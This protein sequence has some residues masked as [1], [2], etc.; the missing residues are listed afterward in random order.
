MY[1]YSKVAYTF[2]G[3]FIF[4]S[5]IGLQYCNEKIVSLCWGLNLSLKTWNNLNFVL[6]FSCSLSFI[7]CTNLGPSWPNQCNIIRTL[8]L[9][10]VLWLT[11]KKMF[12]LNLCFRVAQFVIFVCC[13]PVKG[14]IVFVLSHLILVL[15]VLVWHCQ[16]GYLHPYGHN[17]CFDHLLCH[18]LVSCYFALVFL[19]LPHVSLHLLFPSL[20]Y[21]R[22]LAFYSWHH[23]VLLALKDDKTI[24]SF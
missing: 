7:V 17:G 16:L 20:A 10:H 5:L 24:D 13:F 11:V 6:H 1:F 21:M 18:D 12:L 2:I 22:L 14:G 23:V 8:S 4:F 9:F 15:G 3:I 19:R